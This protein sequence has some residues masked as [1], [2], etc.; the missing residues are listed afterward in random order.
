M[1]QPAKQ[2][3]D[4]P[5]FEGFDISPVDEPPLGPMTTG[6][7]SSAGSTCR[8]WTKKNFVVYIMQLVV[9]T[10]VILVAL[11]NLSLGL[12]K[13]NKDMWVAIVSSCIGYLLPAPSYKRKL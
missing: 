9:L 6:S 3:G 2:K 7:I 11:V 4:S 8:P 5:D 12:Q 1:K 10:I 13:D